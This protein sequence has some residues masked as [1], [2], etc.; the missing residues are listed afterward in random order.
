MEN[1]IAAITD[2]EFVSFTFNAVLLLGMGLAILFAKKLE[3]LR[4][5]LLA[6]SRLIVSRRGYASI[7]FTFTSH[8]HS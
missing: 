1:T 8:V 3:T 4:P 6:K 2:V 7:F 5:K